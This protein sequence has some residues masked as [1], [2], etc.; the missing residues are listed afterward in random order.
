MTPLISL[1]ALS[2]VFLALLLVAKR[3]EEKKRRQVFVLNLISKG[4][5]YTRELYH[6]TVHLYSDGREDLFFFWEKQMPLQTRNFKNKLVSYLK[7]RQ[8][9]YLNTIRDS[10]I[11]KKSDGMSEFFQ[12]ISNIEKGGTIHDGIDDSSQT[13]EN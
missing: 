6:K 7:E 2:G 9:E 1:F 12:K 10:K 3:L 8:F 4:D 13:E 11:L 5:T